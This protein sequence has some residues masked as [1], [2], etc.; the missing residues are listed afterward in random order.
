ME[1]RVKP[2]KF[3]GANGIV[4][5]VVAL[6][7]AHGQPHKGGPHRIDP[8]HHVLVKVLVRIGAALVIGHVVAH[9]ASG[10]ALTDGRI[11]QEIARQLLDGELIEGLVGIEGIDHPVPPQ[12]HEPDAIK[13]VSARVGVARQIKPVLTDSLSIMLRIHQTIDEALISIRTLVSEEGVDFLHSG[14]QTGE[15]EGDTALQANRVGFRIGPEPFGLQ[16]SH[17]EGVDGIAGPL[18]VLNSRQFRSGGHDERPV[19]LPTGSLSHPLLEEFNLSGREGLS[20]LGWR[21]DLV[22]ILRQDPLDQSALFGLTSDQGMLARFER[23][24]G[25]FLTI[26]A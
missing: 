24:K 26:E 14:R 12:P 10:H 15:V 9:E 23:L 2:V 18:A 8:I 4:L 3:L 25:V 20:M 13:V 5:V 21:H 16:S 17:D 19:L 11:G 1:E 7:A 22:G 6:G